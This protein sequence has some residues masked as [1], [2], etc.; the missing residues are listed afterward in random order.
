MQIADLPRFTILGVEVPGDHV[1]LTG[2]FNTISGVRSERSW[3]LLPEYPLIGD[4]VDMNQETR[5]AVFITPLREE[6]G[7]PLGTSAPWLDGFW[8]ANVVLRI[9]DPNW[10]WTRVEFA[11]TDAAEFMQGD[12]RS[13]TQVG[14]AL[15]EGG[16]YLG[17]LPNGWDHEH[18]EICNGK[19]GLHGDSFGYVDTANS[20]LCEKCHGKYAAPHD[21]SFTRDDS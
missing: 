12:V 4:L 8:Q 17:V 5:T 10:V 1:R 14:N 18:C 6:A 15:P 13:W 9:A 11:P 19:I 3:L 20:W 7:I 21:I 2:V 16:R